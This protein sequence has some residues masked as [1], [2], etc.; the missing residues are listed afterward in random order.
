LLSVVSSLSVPKDT[1]VSTNI[2]GTPRAGRKSN[3]NPRT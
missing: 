3:D 2:V 1:M